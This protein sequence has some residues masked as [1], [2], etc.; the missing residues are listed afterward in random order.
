MNPVDW[1]W[2]FDG[3]FQTCVW[4]GT[5]TPSRSSQ[6]RQAIMKGKGKGKG[7]GKGKGKG[8]G[9]GEGKGK[10]KGE[11]KGEGKGVRKTIHRSRGASYTA[12][13]AHH[14]PLSAMHQQ[15]PWNL[16]K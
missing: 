13:A 6:N 11:V 7:T 16:A 5:A 15:L 2:W 1:D 8:K 12:V 14:R 4:I 10:R 9:K 3:C